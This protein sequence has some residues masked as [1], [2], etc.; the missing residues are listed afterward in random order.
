[1]KKT[2][3]FVMLIGTLVALHAQSP[4][5]FKYQAVARNNS[6]VILENQLVS[7]RMDIRVGSPAGSIVYSETHLAM[8]NDF[9]LVNLEIGNGSILIGDFSLIDWAADD[10]FLDVSMDPTGGESYQFLG[11][12]QLLS[13]PYALYAETAG[14]NDDGDWIV[15][16]DD[17][18]N[19]NS[20]NVGI[21]TTSPDGKFVVMDGADTLFKIVD[22]QIRIP[23]NGPTQGIAFMGDYA[24]NSKSPAKYLQW[25]F[26]AGTKYPGFSNRKYGTI[27]NNLDRGYW[28]WDFKSS[29]EI[30]SEWRS[31]SWIFVKL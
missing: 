28:D 17:L 23:G 19:A 15:S 29:G 7:F 27:A 9:G 21:G 22:G 10:H 12:S 14:N 16:G 2:F 13:V 31:S 4:Q 25:S 26:Q 11:S 18:Y 6:G 3:F 1:M 8:T 20:G 24:K 30:G 5:A